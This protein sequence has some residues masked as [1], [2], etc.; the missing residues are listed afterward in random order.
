[1]TKRVI[2]AGGVFTNPTLNR[3]GKAAVS[4]MPG[5][6]C[7]FENGKVKPALD[8]TEEGIKYVANYDYLRGKDVKSAIKLGDWVVCMHPTQ[9]TFYNVTA[10]AG[11]YKKN[12]PLQI[13]EGQVTMGGDASSQF[14]AE[15]TITITTAGDLL[16]VVVK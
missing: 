6:I 2:H 1:M 5:T 10:N 16:R 7:I 9:G 13:I 8:D 4:F 14:F 3:K 11:V 12:D 15:E